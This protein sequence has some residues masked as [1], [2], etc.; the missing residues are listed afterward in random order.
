MREE[1]DENTLEEAFNRQD[2][3]CGY[4]GQKLIKNHRDEDKSQAWEG[5]HLDPYGDDSVD[6]CV[7]LGINCNGRN[8]HFDIGHKGDWNNR[9][10]VPTI[11]E[12]PYC[13]L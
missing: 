8:H 9:D 12:L 5:H 4:C 10:D 1:F 3:R 11:E 13:G 6:N 7:C 2:G